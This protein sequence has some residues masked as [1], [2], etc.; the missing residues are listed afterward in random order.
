MARDPLIQGLIAGFVSEAQEIVE[1]I[2]H[3]LLELERGGADDAALERS[4]EEVAR[5]LHTL[6]GSAGSLGLEDI[7]TL[8][9][10][11]E[12]VVSPLRGSHKRI[13]APAV[14]AVL[15]GL[16]V[17][18]A[19][20]RAHAEASTVLPDMMGALAMVAAAV[21]AP[22]PGSPASAP[23]LAPESMPMSTL[24]SALRHGSTDPVIRESDA[25]RGWRI[26]PRDVSALMREVERLREVRLRLE[27]LGGALKSE[28]DEIGHIVDAL[29][30]GVKVLGA[31][32]IA[33]ILD[34]LRRLVRDLCRTSGKEARI[35]VLGS[36]ISLD[37]H[38]LVGLRESLIHM[39]R[40]SIDHGIELPAVRDRLGKHRE[41]SLVLRVEQHGNL[42]YVEFSDDGAGL[43]VHA[44][45]RAAA[46][47]G[48]LPADQ[49]ASLEARDLHRLIFDAGFSTSETVTETSGRGVGLDVVRRW[50]SSLRG[51]IDVHSVSGQGMRFVLTLP[52]EFGSSPVL[53]VRA[54]EQEFGVPLA[55]VER[56]VAATKQT[57]IVGR[58]QMKLEHGDRLLPL[59]DLGAVLALR[60]TT[61][62]VQGQPVMVLESQGLR[63][64]VA[65]DEVVG[66]RDLVIR[67]LP[68]E[69]ASVNAFQ[70]ASTTAR[71]DLLLIVRPTWLASADLGE[72][73]LAP[74]RRALV[75]DDSLTAR[76]LHRAMLEA[77][78]YVVH[79]VSSAVQ[80]LEWLLRGH[81]DVVVCDVAMKQMDGI[82]FTITAR[83]HEALR[84]IPI[85]LVSAR[86]ESD[87]S[88]RA[89]AAGADAFLSK[90]D[91][92]HGHLLA[93]VTA[94][95]ARRA[96]AS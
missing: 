92:A 65:V 6:K 70:G 96:G 91:C 14:D 46:A 93:E 5:G 95:L 9:H 13:A 75:V 66:D 23:E 51:H 2:T 61:V 28:V 84:A 3:H 64:G 79:A 50:V 20:L 85:V 62:P 73:T 82:A 43:D 16:D 76:A 94:I 57:V 26:R 39:L 21:P 37:R 48:L 32:P 8:A 17:V 53:V 67:A 47:R 25:E 72:S 38:V 88:T 1:A 12:D 29:E 54:A 78:G 34:P 33:S 10:R 83:E 59:R 87:L 40:N 89:I 44:L 42:L 68:V 18:L 45:R 36:D 90:S 56:V 80:A 60:Q 86:Q 58:T 19:R 31:Q 4:Y 27:A 30:D 52:V 35:S 22:I 74:V 63:F 15:K 81:Y 41:G 69:V 24:A 55:A 71:G 11:L 7:A 77:G 49:V